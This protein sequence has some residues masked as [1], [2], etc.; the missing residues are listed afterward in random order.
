[1]KAGLQLWSVQEAMKANPLATLQ[2]VGEMGY[3]GVE[4][5]GYFGLTA[6]ELNT[7]LANNGLVTCASHVNY[8]YLRMHTEEALDYEQSIGNQLVIIPGVRPH[9]L[10]EWYADFEEIERIAEQTEARGMQLAYHNHFKEFLDFPEH[11]LLDEMYERVPHVK[12]EV[13]TY[14]LEYADKDVMAWLT[15]HKDRV[16]SLHIK[17]MGQGINGSESVPLGTGELPLV[18]YVNFAHK[19]GIEWLVVEQEDFSK[20]PPMAAATHN[21]H[22][23]NQLIAEVES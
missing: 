18:D 20:L 23:L 6:A 17:D 21:A 4:F 19:N 10:A 13:D 14:W 22:Y 12:F 1:M 9:S 3:R 15:A 8:D 2:A 7:A 5:A 11:D 16:V